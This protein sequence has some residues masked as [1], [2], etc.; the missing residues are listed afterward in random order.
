MKGKGEMEHLLDGCTKKVSAFTLSDEYT[1]PAR[2]RRILMKLCS[3]Y[4]GVVCILIGSG[5]I[6]KSRTIVNNLWENARYLYLL[7]YISKLSPSIQIPCDL[8]D[9][10]ALNCIGLG[11]IQASEALRGEKWVNDIGS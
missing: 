2:Y 1:S 3:V 11:F 8:I 5:C 10:F 6:S 7:E 9:M 4:S